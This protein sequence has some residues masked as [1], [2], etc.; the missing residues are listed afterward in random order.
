M[1]NY[2]PRA[3]R[4]PFM[5]AVTV[6]L[7]MAMVLVIVAERTMPDSDSTAKIMGI[8]PNASQPAR[9]ARAVDAGGSVLLG[10]GADAVTMEPV[11]VDEATVTEAPATSLTSDKIPT[12]VT[13][14]ETSVLTS[15]TED[16]LTA[17][18]PT[19]E[20]PAAEGTT[21]TQPAATPITKSSSTSTSLDTEPST[22]GPSTSEPSTPEPSTSELSTSVPLT[23]ESSASTSSTW[24]SSTS[25]PSASESS[26]SVSSTTETSSQS[27][28]S[29]SSTSQSPTSESSTSQ[30]S[31]SDPASSLSSTSV[32]SH[33]ESSSTPPLKSPASSSKTSST[34]MSGNERL[35]SKPS[36]PTPGVMPGTMSNPQS[37]T[38]EDM[39]VHDHLG[40][41]TASK[42]LPSGATVIPIATTVSKFTTDVTISGSTTVFTTV[43]TQTETFTYSTDVPTGSIV[44]TSSPKPPPTPTYTGTGTVAFEESWSTE[45]EF[46]TMTT[47]VLEPSVGYSTFTNVITVTAT[48]TITGVV[49]PKVG[50]VTIVD[51]TTIFPSDPGPAHPAQTRPGTPEEPKVYTKVQEV[52]GSSVEIVYSPPP[53]IIVTQDGAKTQTEVV[54]ERITTGVTYIPPAIVV[55]VVVV[56]PDP[57]V[58]EPVTIVQKA[59]PVTRVEV[60]DGVQ[61]T[62]VETPPAQTVI[63]VPAE[64]GVPQ[65]VTQ[66]VVGIAGASA[67]TKVV[68]ATPT[69]P[70]FEPI[71]YTTVRESGGVM[72]TE[73]ATVTPTAAGEPVTVTAVDVVGGSPVTQVVVTTPTAGPNQPISYTITTTINGTP[74][75]QVLVATPTGSEP[76]TFTLT[77]TS[78]GTMSTFTSTILPTTLITTISGTLRTLTST[79]PPITTI[80][81]LPGS[82]RTYTSTASA[83]PTPLP[84]PPT[85]TAVVANTRVYRWT[86]A[87][88]FVGTFLPALLA[89]ALVIP[90]RIIDLNVKLYQPFQ[91]LSKLGHATLMPSSPTPP[92]AGQD[93]LLLNYSGVMAWIGPVV[94]LFRGHPAPFVT[95]LMVLCA[96][97]TVPLATEAVGL[98][99]HGT[100]WVN[101]ASPTCGPALGVSPGP[102]YVL[103]G[104]LAAVAVLLGIAAWLV[105]RW[106]TGVHA[107]PW[108]IAGVAS[109]ARCRHV[110]IPQGG[111]KGMHRA[112]VNKV[113][114]LGFWTDAEGREHYGFVLMDE[115]GRGLT[116]GHDREEG[117]EDLAPAAEAARKRNAVGGDQE[118]G[119]YEDVARMMPFMALRYPWRAIVIM[120]HVAVFVFVI[121][122][123]AYYRGGIKDD[124]KL[125]RFLNSNT[126]GVR[127]VSAVVGVIIALC[128][129]AF[130]IS[131]SVMNP[132]LLLSKQTRPARPSILFTPATNP[133]SGLYAGIRHRQ[134]F[135]SFVSL[136]GV[137][138][139]FL[140]VLL[141]NVP[142]NLAQTGAVATACAVLS[143]IF[144]GTM[145]A[146]LAGSFFVRYPPM[147]VDPRSVAGLMWYVSRSEA[148]LVD[149][150]GVSLLNGKERERRVC[151]KGRRYYYGVL[152]VAGSSRRLGV[153]CDG[154]SGEEEM[155][156]RGANQF[157]AGPGCRTD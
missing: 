20:A 153:E 41:T 102:A 110:R 130:F 54:G 117:D 108:S 62:V 154:T 135:L 63:R 107:N 114:A 71:T 66:T 146:V 73:V 95:T 148:L 127:F 140:P 105:G 136:A 39:F 80:S 94:S 89:V 122:Y 49:I 123:H 99:L 14:P 10:D 34:P 15:P 2:K 42:S 3:L 103:V 97:F 28:T 98:K 124:G 116:G 121:Y 115:A 90:L 18:A 104:V 142:F 53:V 60:V 67:V 100:C 83:T 47:T 138:S 51:Y 151:E 112:V 129:Q 119:D 43:I 40:T 147:P 65:P 143:C 44:I 77:T 69:G 1:P 106:V 81:S 12:V 35:Q 19:S 156:Y 101:T 9:L 150:E 61:R 152:P 58:G 57:N 32:S 27:P 5:I 6:M 134:V 149:L 55:N 79:P 84:P 139:E 4:R 70:P 31:R 21:E 126:F 88:I 76:V 7:L 144:L 131:V 8:H 93:T 145:I 87:D 29:E 132:F 91:A 113:Y 111:E 24:E 72:F 92:A 96:S 141:A 155:G 128:W 133:F 36:I 13:E 75:T 157:A 137:L 25:E 23:S 17:A 37:S 85:P 52:P 78:G 56:T 30:S 125:W 16:S 59:D 33:T 74:T 120:L 64:G 82:T 48:S 68:V 86:E 38:T 118:E 50:E 11:D 46:S 45:W 109:L 22:S 26:T